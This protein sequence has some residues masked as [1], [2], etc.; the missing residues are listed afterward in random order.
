M[1]HLHIFGYTASLFMGLM[2]GLTGGGGAILTVPILVYL[3]KIGGHEATTYSLGIIGLLSLW[4]ARSAY[5][6]RQI[7]YSVALSFGVAGILGVLFSR[8]IV[9]KLIPDPL[10]IAQFH[11]SKDSFLIVFFA[12]IMFIA[13]FNM[14]KSPKL[15]TPSNSKPIT[16]TQ[17]SLW[18]F[19]IGSL[20]GFVGAGGGFLMIPALVKGVKLPIKIAIG[21]SLLIIAAQSLLG[22][23][24]DLQILSQMNGML[25]L[26]VIIL[27]MIGMQLGIYLRDKIN[28]ENLRKGFGFFIL[29]MALLMI[30]LETRKVMI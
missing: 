24:G 7:D 18:G 8:N 14:I 3:F 29:G 23:F 27:A 19:L 5:K 4:G 20:A 13:S 26:S 16:T 10:T 11:L 12:I 2:L 28:S 6:K 30:Y 25:F 1:T 21:T 9:L 17:N 15:D 22:L